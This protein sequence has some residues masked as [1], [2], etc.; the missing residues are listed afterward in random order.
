MAS[1]IENGVLSQSEGVLNSFTARGP[2][3]LSKW[4]LTKKLQTLTGKEVC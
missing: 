1:D 4:K 3:A 2:A